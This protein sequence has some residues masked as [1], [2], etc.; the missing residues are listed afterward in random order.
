MTRV[1]HPLHINAFS[2]IA[3][4][5]KNGNRMEWDPLH[6]NAFSSIADAETA[7]E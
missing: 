3:D 5:D 4:I 7:W 6:I 2:S 1:G